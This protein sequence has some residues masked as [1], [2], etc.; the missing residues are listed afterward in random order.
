MLLSAA[1]ASA[2]ENQV[3][4]LPQ[5]DTSHEQKVYSTDE[6]GFWGAAEV[7]GGYSCRL[8]KSNFGMA[9]MDVVGGY[10]F[11]EYVRVGIGFGGRYYIDNSQVRITRSEW[12]FPLF[13]NVR[14]NFIPTRY[15]NAVPY[16]SVDLGGTFRDG[17]LFRPSVGMR[18]GQKRSTFLL[19]V[20]Y[21]GQKLHSFK[22]DTSGQRVEKREF[23]SFIT[24]KLGYEY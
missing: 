16:Y 7:T 24:L 12:A 8:S 6:S 10:R 1:L 18:F 11:N 13:A 3:T 21:T 4:R 15:R 2:Q 17:F 23:V 22:L 19:S 5:V 14:G 9:E 20:G